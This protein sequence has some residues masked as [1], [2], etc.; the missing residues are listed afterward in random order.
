MDQSQ[1]WYSCQDHWPTNQP[2]GFFL[3]INEQEI[4]KTFMAFLARSHRHESNGAAKLGQSRHIMWWTDIDPVL[5]QDSPVCSQESPVSRMCTRPER[6]QQS[7]CY[8][9]DGIGPYQIVYRLP[10]IG[11]SCMI[12]LRVISPQSC[13]CRPHFSCVRTH[14]HFCIKLCTGY[15]HSWAG[16]TQYNL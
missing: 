11:R 7:Y 10:P 3:F 2:E 1:A 9:G 4:S 8:Q 14:S 16:N 15:I 12:V 5:Q 6:H 13:N